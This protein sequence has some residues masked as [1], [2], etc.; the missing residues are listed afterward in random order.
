M[1]FFVLILSILVTTAAQAQIASKGL[2]LD[3]DADT[4]VEVEDGDRVVKWIN[5]VTTSA[6]RDFVKQ[7]AGRKEPGSGRHQWLQTNRAVEGREFL[8]WQSAKRR[9][10]RGDLGQCDR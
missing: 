1:R 10:V 2:I 9:H 4:G 7:D 6:A 3:L 8:F 5:Q